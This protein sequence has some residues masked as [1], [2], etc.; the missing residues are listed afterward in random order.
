MV[1]R[2]QDR[3]CAWLGPGQLVLDATCTTRSMMSGEG[4][5]PLVTPAC[6]RWIPL[7]H[8]V[9]HL[10][11]NMH[12]NQFH[13]R[14]GESGQGGAESSMGAPM[15]DSG[16]TVQRVIMIMGQ[17]PVGW[18]WP[19]CRTYPLPLTLIM[20]SLQQVLRPGVR[21]GWQ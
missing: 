19:K 6:C 20:L 2:G 4:M 12:D 16:V 13:Y 10:F 18:S 1:K 17:L 21:T 14:L 8:E 3:R 5:K 7:L 11:M 9:H 15:A